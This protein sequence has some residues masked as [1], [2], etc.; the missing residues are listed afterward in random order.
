M[1]IGLIGL[2]KM[3]ANMTERLLLG[4]HKVVCYDKN[5]EPLKEI[6]AKGAA[7]AESIQ[8][9]IQKL[10]KPRII[11]LM[12]PAGNIVD[13]IIKRFIIRHKSG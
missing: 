13:K 9:F 5:Q 11:W 1:E 7:T 12:I 6:A 8:D 4:G 2:G 3:G 10:K